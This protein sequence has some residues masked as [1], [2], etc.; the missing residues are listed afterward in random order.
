[1]IGTLRLTALIIDLIHCKSKQVF[2][3]QTNRTEAHA[4]IYSIR[5]AHKASF[6]SIIVE[7]LIV[8][9]PS[10]LINY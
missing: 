10:A 4:L 9:F 1:M 3:L 2:S 5:F 6:H 7:K 8:Q